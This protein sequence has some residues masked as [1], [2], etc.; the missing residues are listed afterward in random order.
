MSTLIS[1][2]QCQDLR[3]FVLVKIAEIVELFADCPVTRDEIKLQ[4]FVLVKQALQEVTNGRCDKF[5][6]LTSAEVLP[7]T[8]KIDELGDELVEQLALR[9]QNYP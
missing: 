9:F 5:N 4:V 3:E 2:K 6:Q 1:E 8:Q 7:L